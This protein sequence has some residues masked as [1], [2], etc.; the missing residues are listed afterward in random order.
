MSVSNH[1]PRNC[2]ICLTSLTGRQSKY[3]SRKCKG[4]HQSN[5]FYQ[6]QKQ[7]S[8]TRKQKLVSMLGGKCLNCGYSKS[9]R[10][11]DFHHLDPSKKE[12]RLDSRKLAGSSWKRILKEVEKCVLLCANCHREVHEEMDS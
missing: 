1:A 3:C 4:K 11:L 8:I 7:R 2:L 9:L 5:S 10:A 6:Y 12:I